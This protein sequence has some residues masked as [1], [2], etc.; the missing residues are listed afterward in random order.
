MQQPMMANDKAREKDP[1]QINC[2]KYMLFKILRLTTSIS[3]GFNATRQ[4]I[5]V[6]DLT[7]MI[8][9]LSV[10]YGLV[11]LNHNSIIRISNLAKCRSINRKTID[12][13]CYFLYLLP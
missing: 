6:S 4:A 3:Y 1:L 7:T 10:Q 12:R 11:I 8:T 9:F 13:Y 2:S 5:C